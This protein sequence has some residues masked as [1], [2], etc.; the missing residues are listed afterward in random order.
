MPSFMSHSPRQGGDVLLFGNGAATAASDGTVDGMCFSNYWAGSKCMDL[1][2][3]DITAGKS[4]FARYVHSGDAL[5]LMLNGRSYW[6]KGQ[7]KLCWDW[8]TN[9]ACAGYD[10]TLGV[11]ATFSG[12]GADPANPSCIWA[13]GDSA[14]G[15]PLSATDAMDGG[16][17]KQ[18]PATPNPVNDASRTTQGQ[19]VTIDVRANDSTSSPTANLGVPSITQAPANG[20]ATVDGSGNVIYTPKPGFMGTDTFTYQVCIQTEPAQCATASVSI[21]VLG[22]TASADS[23]STKPDV[24][25]TI[26]ILGN[27]ASSDPINAPLAA[28]ATA[29]SPP[30]HGQV[31]YNADGTATYTPTAGFTGTDTFEYQICTVQGSYPNP[32]CA[33]AQ[34]TVVVSATAT[35]PGAGGSP[36]PVPVNSP[37]ALLLL[38]VGLA[39]LTA[40]GLRRI[41]A[42]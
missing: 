31:V 8:A 6:Q 42:S 24:P 2:G 7:Q 29:V 33:I 15:A 25:V 11:V 1:N 14:G 26:S 9:A 27:D 28:A 30:A 40:A 16:R 32:A 36:T 22:V 4:A 34:V 3:N 35:P 20:T 10:N 21:D 38:S 37:W 39:G 41:R 18:A 5:A 12:A 23:A 13:A 19:P 17:C